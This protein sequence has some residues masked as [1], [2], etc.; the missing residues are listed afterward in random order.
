MSIPVIV[1]GDAAGRYI[2][3]IESQRGQVSVARHAQ[4]FSEVLG[5]A[6]TGIARAVLIV[7]EHEE[8][9]R[10]LLGQLA[11]Q[12]LGIVMVSDPGSEV[13]SLPYA[14]HI[15]TLDEDSAVL[16]SIVRSV[17]Q[18]Q[19]AAG[20]A[21]PG[22]QTGAGE[23]VPVQSKPGPAEEQTHPQED[24]DYL[25]DNTDRRP[26]GEGS[27]E[28][29]PGQTGQA[30]GKIVTVWGGAGSPGRSTVAVNLA[31]FALEK[32]LRVCLVDADTYA[33]SVSALLG[34]LED[35]SGL[36]Q[37]CHVAERQ[38]VTA[39][40]IS[41]AVSTIKVA[42]FFLDIL[43]GITRPNRWA[44]LRS[45]AL[46]Q[47]LDALRSHYDLVVVDT[48][49]LIEADEELSFDGLAPQRNAATITALEKAD[50]IIFLGSGDVLGIPRA[51]RSFEDLR[52]LL[53]AAEVVPVI[54]VW[55]NRLR[56]QAVGSSPEESI[57]AA[58]Q[59]FGPHQEIRGFLPYARETIDQSW[60]GGKTLLESAPK[61]ELSTA[62]RE[63]LI[64]ALE[65]S[66]REQD[67]SPRR[68][69]SALVVRRTGS[70]IEKP[71]S[72]GSKGLAQ[73]LARGFSRKS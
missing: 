34:M 25:V 23:E 6:H 56:K 60:L 29:K 38:T 28:K 13:R 36:A 26:T 10:S 19:D 43:T 1:F 65:D 22:G 44:E 70:S 57:R 21:D 20:A 31:A 35:Y 64:T 14:L 40:N 53:A 62:L 7:G 50:E 71:E 24:L 69:F 42:G 37:M 73:K 15:S 66:P 58:W 72:A 2:S 54:S 55:I 9:S 51:I 63:L 59:R 39:E 46:A 67:P 52:N 41:E 18:G 11:E 3:A 8:I 48:G 16:E 12:E 68:P 30:P 49:A 33:P 27:P 47:V 17:E 5:F 61:S 32:N 4:D 45:Q